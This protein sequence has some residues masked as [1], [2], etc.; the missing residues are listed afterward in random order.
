[1][2]VS[3]E[4]TLY[5]CWSALCVWLLFFCSSA[6][7]ASKAAEAGIAAYRSGEYRQA[8]HLLDESLH[9]ELV[10]DCDAMYYRA[11]AFVKLDRPQWA[12]EHYRQA[13]ALA[14]D[15]AI[16]EQCDQAISLLTNF[17]KS[18]TNGNDVPVQTERNTRLPGQSQP[19]SISANPSQTNNESDSKPGEP[20]V[21]DLSLITVIE[22]D[23]AVDGVFSAVSKAVSLIPAR[24][25]HQIADD[26]ITWV[27][28]PKL[29]DYYPAM[30][31]MQ[32]RGW[33][34]GQDYRYIA[35]CYSPKFNKVLIAVRALRT[36]D[37]VMATRG[38]RMQTTLHETGHA[39]DKVLKF[40]SL[41]Q[42]FRGAYECDCAKLSAVQRQKL[43]YF[44]QE[45]NAGLSETFAE[46]FAEILMLKA[47]VPF[48][49]PDRI[50]VVFPNTL[51]VM[52]R[53]L[54]L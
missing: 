23:T 10:G 41:D 22:G 4:K 28:C 26:G 33:T 32:S 47:N 6:L 11:N 20:S 19:S 39:Y 8:A 44:L 46:L 18:K 30:A 42:V 51:D 29:V 52:I 21:Y 27:V 36:S 48:E 1:M 31:N 14:K 49:L 9:H 24:I 38:H 45:G 17:Q 7:A 40:Y 43:K 34:K 37:G 2:V 5:V 53:L 25:K 13:H 3:F 16:I 12:M 54:R 50:D 15:N 35:G